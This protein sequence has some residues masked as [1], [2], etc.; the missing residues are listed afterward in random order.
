M[1]FV[2]PIVCI[3]FGFFVGLI[4][5]RFGIGGAIITI[6]FYR[7]VFGLSGPAA[8]ATS[9]PLTIPTALTGALVFHKK[10]LIRYKTALIAGI[11][12][13]VFSVIGAYCTLFVPSD[14]LMITTAFMFFGLA[15]MIS[16]EKKEREK[17]TALSLFEKAKAS[18]FIGCVA[19]FASG[20]FGIGGGVILVPLLLTIRKLPLKEAIPTSLA[21]MAIY[22]IPGSIAHYSIG[23]VHTDL[24]AFVLIGSIIGA[25]AGAKETLKVPEKEL[26]MMFVWLLVFLGLMLIYN[27]VFIKSVL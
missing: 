24:L 10:K 4:S 26:R 1:D 11:F 17:V 8:I 7:I 25:N 14:I 6:P 19:G 12:G 22:A 15:Y 16:K 2:V 21:T 27:E 20:F 18:I 23:N 3:I 5:S 13:S 9:L